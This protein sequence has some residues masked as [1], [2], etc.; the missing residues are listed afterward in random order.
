MSIVYV[1]VTGGG[2]ACM[3]RTVPLVVG[4]VPLCFSWFG[5]HVSMSICWVPGAVLQGLPFS[6]K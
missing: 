3:T 4:P 1:H 2:S 6:G 5:G